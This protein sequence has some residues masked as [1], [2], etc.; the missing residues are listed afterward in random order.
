MKK[1][2]LVVDNDPDYLETCA[3]ILERAGYEVIR[4]TSFEEAE[5]VLASSWVQLIVTDVRLRNDTDR[6]D[7]SG[8]SLAKM[9]PYRRIPKIIM[10][11][12]PDYDQVRKALGPMVDG[13]PPAVDFVS[14]KE[15][16]KALL[17][18]IEKALEIYTQINEKLEIKFDPQS[19]LSFQQLADWITPGLERVQA[20]SRAEELEYLFRLA[21]QQERLIRI[22]RL[23]WQSD[24]RAALLVYAFADHQPQTSLFV[25]CGR[26]SL[27]AEEGK[28]AS[29]FAAN[30]AGLHRTQ[31][32]RTETVTHLGLN[33][34]TLVG[35]DPDNMS[36]L[37]EL[38]RSGNEKALGKTIE[39]LFQDTLGYCFSEKYLS[40]EWESLGALCQSRFGFDYSGLAGEAYQSRLKAVAQNAPLLGVK[41]EFA[42]GHLSFQ[43]GDK[44]DTYPDPINLLSRDFGFS[45]LINSPIISSGYRILT[46]GAGKAWLT[47][48][49][50]AGPMP[51]FWNFVMLEAMIRFDWVEIVKPAWLH[52]LE[53]S[54]VADFTLF[55]TSDLETPLRPVARAIQT[56]RKLAKNI[57]G[58]DQAAYHWG[59]LFEAMRRFSGFN[60][61]QPLVKNELTRMMHVLLGAAVSCSKLSRPA[62]LNRAKSGSGIE[63]DKEKRLV[64]V[65]GQRLPLRGQGYDLLC[66]LAERRGQ[67]YTSREIIERVFREEYRENDSYQNNRLYVAIS[68][69]RKMIEDDPDNPR[70]LLNEPGGGYWLAED[71]E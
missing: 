26:E 5:Q 15:G 69:L 71:S 11:R 35:A 10:T 38:Y 28:R 55:N 45:A 21:F 31:L 51:Q 3:D 22:A 1:K 48:F 32:K 33:V 29:D 25:V 30:T 59:I 56:I 16:K 19:R 41:L 37:F 60:P 39:S 49:A 4:A 66:L 40:V 68:R 64:L 8:I 61:E 2:L 46:D 7:I 70:L 13:L 24:G 65:R 6:R 57:L 43:F 67:L 47:D 58:Q 62:A 42:P 44:A 18:A 27:M 23:Y 54:L 34:Y 9:T 53:N 17:G 63:I 20:A 52:D 36:S 14:K 50:G 12:W